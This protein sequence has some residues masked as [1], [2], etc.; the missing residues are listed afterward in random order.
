MEIFMLIAVC[1]TISVALMITKKREPLHLSFAALCLAIA[2]HRGGWLFDQFSPHIAWLFVERL[3]SW[4]SPPRDP[5]QPHLYQGQTLIK[6][7]DI[8]SATLFSAGL[9]ILLFTPLGRWEPLT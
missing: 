8:R 2:F 1:I 4:P 9:A 7:S 5:V 6:K 3:G